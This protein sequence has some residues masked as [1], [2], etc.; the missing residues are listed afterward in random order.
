MPQ[1]G[2]CAVR[3]ELRGV[4]TGANAQVRSLLGEGTKCWAV[5][6]QQ[7]AKQKLLEPEGARFSPMK[8]SSSL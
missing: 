5:W 8:R 2:A 1:S 6:C 4:N 7:A 3:S